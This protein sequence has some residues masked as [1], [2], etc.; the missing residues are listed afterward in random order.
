MEDRRINKN[1]RIDRSRE[2]RER[3]SLQRKGDARNELGIRRRKTIG[4]RFRRSSEMR[5]R[6][7]AGSKW[8]KVREGEPA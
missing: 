2:K 3:D 8:M 7:R 5:K 6:R 4:N 1:S